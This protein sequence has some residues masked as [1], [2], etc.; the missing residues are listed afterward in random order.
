MRL[1]SGPVPSPRPGASS[2]H[3]RQQK[4]DDR[5]DRRGDEHEVEDAARQ[6]PGRILAVTRPYAGKRRDEGA[7]QRGSRQQ[8]KHQVRQAKGDEV[9]VELRLRAVRMGDDHAAQKPQHAA[10][11]EPRGNNHRGEGEAM[12]AQGRAGGYWRVVIQRAGS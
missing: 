9:G 1:G 6:L 4:R 10:A 5:E 7:G 8:L 2:G 3:R 12:G 11:Q